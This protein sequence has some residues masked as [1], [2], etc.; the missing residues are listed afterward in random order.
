[1]VLGT[2]SA[3]KFEQVPSTSEHAKEKR[4]EAKSPKST[5]PNKSKSAKR[6][7]S[8]A[9]GTF[10]I[11]QR[12]LGV[13]GKALCIHQERQ[14]GSGQR[15]WWPRRAKMRQK[16]TRL[17]ALSRRNGKFTT[18]WR[19][20]FGPDCRLNKLQGSN[21]NVSIEATNFDDDFAL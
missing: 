3:A 4:E 18:K 14:G 11:S 13:P 10:T 6:N 20:Q 1:M 15:T 16:A 19:R 9:G 8:I 21:K 5:S 17:P 12:R 7:M 2:R